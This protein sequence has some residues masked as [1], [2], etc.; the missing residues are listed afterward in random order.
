[1][2][3]RI[4]RS[5]A[6]LAGVRLMLSG[7]W[8]MTL[9]IGDPSRV[10]APSAGP[11]R[12]T[13][14]TGTDGGYELIVDSPGRYGAIVETL[15]GR[16]RY[17]S[18]EAEVPDADTWTFDVDYAGEAVT[19]IVVDRGTE[20]GIPKAS[21]HA[22]PQGA[23]A[24]GSAQATAGGDGRFSLELEPGEYRL[25]ADHEGYAAEATELT[26]SAGGASDVRIALSPGLAIRGR[27]VDG[28]GRGVGGLF[29]SAHAADDPPAGGRIAVSLADGS[30]RVEGL[31]DRPHV[32]L[33]GSRLAGFAVQDGVSPDAE[34]E[35]VLRLRPG[36]LAVVRVRD[37][38]GA[39][40][41]QAWA[42]V[43]RVGTVD[44]SAAVDRTALS[45]AAERIELASPAG[46][47]TVQVRKDA[48]EAVATLD[49]P[50]GG[51]VEAE[52]VLGEPSG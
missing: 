31:R 32:L 15:D 43:L 5:G 27:V 8:S 6:P 47:I 30:F 24:V 48:R 36:G 10:A 29:V 41:E 13:A 51:A 18:R 2:S 20:A 11:E 14:V 45:D 37:P 21:V 49:V 34:E 9:H 38:D 28:A 35:A 19:G 40:V 39:P 22:R 3:G 44:V 4:T 50:A 23:G 26:V 17:P 46:R 33:T 12:F 16:T 1:V 25:S 7:H 42:R 52:L